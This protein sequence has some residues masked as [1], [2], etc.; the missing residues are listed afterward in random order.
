MKKFEIGKS[1]AY[2]FACSWDTV[3]VCTI[4]KRTEKT[5]TFKDDC[6]EVK[7]CRIRVYNNCEHCK[8]TG[9]YSMAPTLSA[10]KMV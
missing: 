5:V 10:D 9:S 4:I 7:T 2:R 1:Y 6:N 8:P 3:V